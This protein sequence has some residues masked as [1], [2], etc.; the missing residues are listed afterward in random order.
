MELYLLKS[1]LIRLL[2][3]SGRGTTRRP[4]CRLSSTLT[5]LTNRLLRYRGIFSMGE[6]SDMV[7]QGSMC[8]LCGVVFDDEP[9]GFPRMCKECQRD[10]KQTK[11]ETAGN[12]RVPFPPRL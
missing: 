5:G 7:V 10:N 3:T 2:T 6:I 11:R 9:Q 1:S 4:K 8:E 12:G